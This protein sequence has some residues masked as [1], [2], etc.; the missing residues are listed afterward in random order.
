[1]NETKEA[2]KKLKFW[3]MMLLIFGSLGGIIGIMGLPAVIDPAKQV[4][5]FEQSVGSVKDPNQLASM[6][7]TLEQINHPLFRFYTV[8]MLV[9]SL[10]LVAS[11]FQANLHLNKNQIISKWPYYLHLGKIAVAI[12]VSFLSGSLLLNPRLS[13]ATLLLNIV[14]SLPAIFVLRLMKK[15][16][17]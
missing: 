4:E 7:Q 9:F 12:L 3:N 8:V 15:A 10:I 6:A 1:M 11:F 14:W 5:L 17:I 16:E 2:S 13:V